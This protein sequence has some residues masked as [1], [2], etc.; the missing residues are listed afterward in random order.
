MLRAFLKLR[1]LATRLG[2]ESLVDWI[3]QESEGYLLGVHLPNDRILG[4]SY[5][6]TFSGP[7]GS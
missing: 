4:V 2:S 5:K 3:R 7:F 1:M 6:G